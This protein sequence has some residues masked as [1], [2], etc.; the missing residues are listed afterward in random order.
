M[1]VVKD[2]KGYAC[3]DPQKLMVKVC[4]CMDGDVCVNRQGGGQFKPQTELGPGGIGLLLL[5]ILLLLCECD[6]FLILMR[7]HCNTH[8]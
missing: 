6:S 2:N 3:P 7:D 5:G 4:D 1:L 8:E